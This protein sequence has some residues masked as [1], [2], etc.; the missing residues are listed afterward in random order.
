MSDTNLSREEQ[1]RQWWRPKPHWP[2][3][4]PCEEC[5]PNSWR[6]VHRRGLEA[7]SESLRARLAA[8][9]RER[10]QARADLATVLDCGEDGDRPECACRRHLSANLGALRERVRA[11]AEEY[12]DGTDGRGWKFG[13]EYQRGA[14]D[15]IASITGRLR[16]LLA[17]GSDE[18]REGT[19]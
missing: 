17:S 3:D 16:S 14:R 4:C 15:W 7:D 10:G 6:N 13:T 19:T 11:L 12:V 1:A 2:A 18:G 8:A 9:E 5:S